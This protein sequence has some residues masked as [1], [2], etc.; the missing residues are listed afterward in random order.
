MVVAEA[1]A[2][3]I[4]SLD[5]E[6]ALPGP[7]G[8]EEAIGDAH[9]EG[10]LTAA[11]GGW[12]RRV[13]LVADLRQWLGEIWRAIDVVLHAGIDHAAADGR[14]DGDRLVRPR[15][16]RGEGDLRQLRQRHRWPNSIQEDALSQEVQEVIRGHDPDAAPEARGDLG[17]IGGG[18]LLGIDDGQHKA[19]LRGRREN[20]L[21][22]LLHI[23]HAHRLPDQG[24]AER[25][26]RPQRCASRQEAA[27]RRLESQASPR[28]V[29]VGRGDVDHGERGEVRA[30]RRFVGLGHER[31]ER[32]RIG[33]RQVAGAAGGHHELI[34]A[35]PPGIHIVIGEERRGQLCEER[36]QLPAEGKVAARGIIP[37]GAHPP[38]AKVEVAVARE[39]EGDV[40]GEVVF[41]QPL[42][43]AQRRVG[44]NARVEREVGHVRAGHEARRRGTRQRRHRVAWIA[45][46]KRARLHRRTDALSPKEECPGFQLPQKRAQKLRLF[47]HSRIQAHGQNLLGDQV[48]AQAHLFRLE[49]GELRLVAPGQQVLNGP[50]TRLAALFEARQVF[51]QL[52]ARIARRG[53]HREGVLQAG[54]GRRQVDRLRLGRVVEDLPLDAIGKADNR[55]RGRLLLGLE[56]TDGVDLIE[57]GAVL[58]GVNAVEHRSLGAA[59]DDPLEAGERQLRGRIGFSQ[60]HQ[61]GGCRRGFGGD[62]RRGAGH[63]DQESE[64]YHRR[65]A[66]DSHELCP[67]GKSAPGFPPRTR[68]PVACPGLAWLHYTRG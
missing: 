6:R 51:Y 18:E 36:V 46:E 41:H 67:D 60:I 43:L 26:C 37:Q 64:Q 9:L 27:H 63:R 12:N 31:L 25:E 5:I 38:Q 1:V 14:L 57:P 17:H 48:V 32:L 2:I 65:N 40:A 29:V 16:A 55:L 22:R 56:A 19:L 62:R 49:H 33:R 13:V 3:A 54:Q 30:A 21:G 15:L 42:I 47:L 59:I 58:R 11:Q 20:R 4:G 24:L 52:A 7:G 23:G 39:E 34:H 10:E 66:Q 8:A 68:L 61:G 53:G 45:D 50:A 44:G 35:G 28:P